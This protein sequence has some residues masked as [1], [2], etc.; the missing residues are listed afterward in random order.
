MIKMILEFMVLVGKT[1]KEGGKEGKIGKY[2]SMRK[3]KV[4]LFFTEECKL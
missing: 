1:R 3:Q 2:L 4:N